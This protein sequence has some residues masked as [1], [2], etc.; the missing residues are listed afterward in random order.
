[1]I[2]Y[3]LDHHSDFYLTRKLPYIL[4]NNGCWLYSGS[5]FSKGYGK[6]SISVLI[7]NK[8]VQKTL[9]A[10]RL[11]YYLFRDK[12][13]F[14]SKLQVLHKCDNPQCINP[15]HLFV[16]TNADNMKD[17]TIKGRHYQ[18]LKTHCKYGHEFTKENIYSY[19]RNNNRYCRTCRTIAM[20]K[21]NDKLQEK[22]LNAKSA[23]Q[24]TV[25]ENEVN[26]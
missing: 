15:N 7:S 20:R 19:D 10:H 13:I 2:E 25:R 11:S 23:V 22:R 24:Q 1:M 16:G 6:V 3:N 5:L 9:K 21:Y 8:K 12:L 17:K 4:S 26:S 18:T 14:K